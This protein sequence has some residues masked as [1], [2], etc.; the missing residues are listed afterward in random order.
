[1]NR[2]SALTALVAVLSAPV[3]TSCAGAALCADT[4]VDTVSAPDKSHDAVVLSRD[5]GAT[6]SFTTQI[7]IVEAGQD[8]TTGQTVFSA[9]G[10]HGEAELV[11]GDVIRLE[12]AWTSA[13]RLVVTYDEN[14]RVFDDEPHAD[15]VDVDYVTSSFST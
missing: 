14:A 11:A 15:G 1:M 10:D 7:S 3:L 13:T 2:T 12:V 6:T 9:D 5:C 4:V 8:H